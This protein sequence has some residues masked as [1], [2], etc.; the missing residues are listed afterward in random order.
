[1]RISV[2]ALAASLTVA[3]L[4]VGAYGSDADAAPQL[5]IRDGTSNIKDGSSNTV[6]AT[7]QRVDDGI[8]AVLVG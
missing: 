2:P 7:A 4:A 3:A 1:M 8:V 6:R 5:D